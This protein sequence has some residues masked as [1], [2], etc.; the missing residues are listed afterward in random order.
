MIDRVAILDVDFHHGNG[1]QSIFYERDEVLFASIHGDPLTEFPFYL[2]YA[3]ETGAG[4]GQGYNLNLPLPADTQ[5]EQW[6]AALEVACQ[7]VS[8]YK[9][10]TVCR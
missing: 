6:F 9:A 7:R 5:A 8:D 3:D 10:G 4:A 1:T 2:G